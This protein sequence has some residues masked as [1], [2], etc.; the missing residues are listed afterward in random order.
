M[1]FWL[2]LATVATGLLIGT[3]PPPDRFRGN[4]HAT[5]QFETPRHINQLCRTKDT[6][7][8]SRLYACI[9]RDGHIIMPNPC[10]YP[11]HPGSYDELLCH[12]LGHINGWPV[13]HGP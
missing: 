5:V 13:T 11:M 8:G 10:V 2:A 12:E 1:S 6:P 7:A 9:A 3:S 4:T